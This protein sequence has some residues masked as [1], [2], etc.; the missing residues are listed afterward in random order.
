[1]GIMLPGAGNAPTGRDLN[2]FVAALLWCVGLSLS[3]RCFAMVG[4]GGSDRFRCK[5]GDKR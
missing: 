5:I 1:M 4:R 3:V 2:S